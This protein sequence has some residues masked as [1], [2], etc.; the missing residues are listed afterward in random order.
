MENRKTYISV[1][2]VV[3][4]FCVVLMHVNN[5]GMTFTYEPY[6]V[7]G[8]LIDSICYFAVPV[9]FMIS[10]ANLIDY[11]ERYTTAI[12]FR[13]RFWKAFFP[14]LAWS[15]LAMG[16]GIWRGEVAN[17]HPGALLGGIFSV[18]Y[19]NSYWFFIPL[20]MLYLAIPV[21][22]CV[23]NRQRAFGYMIV[24]AFA[25]N[26]LLPLAGYFVYWLPR[27]G[28]IGMP[29]VGGYVI[30]L[31]MGYYIDHYEIPRAWRICIYVLGAASLV[32]IS[33]GT[34]YFSYQQGQLF[35]L[36]KGYLS[37]PVM[38]YA[39]AVFLAVKQL[40]ERGR[41]GVLDKLARP[42]AGLTLGIF[43]SHRALMAAAELLSVGDVTSLPR[44][45]LEA[46][47]IFLLSAALTWVLQKIPGIRR[48]V[49]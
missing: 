24:T 5:C 31:L 42:F 35:S 32:L 48:I 34:Q 11:R 27:G 29:L 26:Y 15:L 21:L 23:Q 12:Y 49:P 37:L 38:L 17:L 25:L 45:L 41:L 9:F 2:S 4:C 47:A 20:F 44:C 18:A 46:V 1:L 30:Y 7:G 3:S 19:V 28:D 40:G 14:F 36:F 8:N 6:W 43:L 22:S 39:G 10:G 16:Y 33:Y 13:K